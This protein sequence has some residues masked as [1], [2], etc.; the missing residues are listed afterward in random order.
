MVPR[1]FVGEGRGAAGGHRGA[2]PRGGPWPSGWTPLRQGVALPQMDQD[3]APRP[4]A[5]RGHGLARAPRRA[6]QAPARTDKCRRRAP[7]GGLVLARPGP[8]RTGGAA[9]AARRRRAAAPYPPTRG[10]LGGAGYRGAPRCAGLPH[11]P[12]T[13]RDHPRGQGHVNP[14]DLL[15][16]A[17]ITEM[18][19]CA[20]RR[21]IGGQP[22][23]RRRPW[24]I[25]GARSRKHQRVASSTGGRCFRRS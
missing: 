19:R 18:A 8:G 16:G 4:R 12:R 7:A 5:H 21:T 6:P 11:R 13:R 15:T 17:Q 25:R 2:W 14:H 24:W 9:R 10:A 23:R 22:C 1:H 20:A 3:Q